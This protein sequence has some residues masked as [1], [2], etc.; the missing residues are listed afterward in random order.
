LEGI[1]IGIDPN[2]KVLSKAYPYIAKRLLT[3]P[4]PELR[5]SLRD[6]LFKDGSFRWNRL[7]N[8]LN[9]AG[10]SD[11]FDFDR[12][13]DQASDFLFSERGQFIRD[14]LV[15]ELI[16]TIDIFGRRTWFNLT[17]VVR[18]QVGM[19]VQEL[20]V[21]LQQK[22]KAFEHISNIVKILRN[23]NGFDPIRLIAVGT[24]LLSKPE[25]HYLGQR[26]AEGLLQ[27]SLTRLIRTVLLD[28]DRDPKPVM[29]PIAPDRPLLPSS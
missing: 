18:E 23:T 22:S 10:N 15:S 24:K 6:L 28:L 13:L 29:P 25:T 12:L 9:N 4:S 27:K 17:A 2:F 16:D 19:A 8:L 5:A 7:E 26:V 1:A 20:P 21:E 3:D 14:R 11:E